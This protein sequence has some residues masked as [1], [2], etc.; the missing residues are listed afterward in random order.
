M[1]YRDPRV[2]VEWAT[3]LCEVDGKYGYFH[4]W[5]QRSDVIDASPFKGGHPGGQVSQVYGLVEF[6]DGIERI[7]PTH[8]KFCDLRKEN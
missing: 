2:T 8:I 5:E 6:P 7:D 1:T 3:R 4:T